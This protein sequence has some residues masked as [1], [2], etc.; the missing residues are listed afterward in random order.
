M[1]LTFN[2]WFD[3]SENCNSVSDQNTRIR[4]T[5][6]PGLF[7][8]LHTANRKQ[9]LLP[10]YRQKRDAKDFLWAENSYKEALIVQKYEPLRFPPP[11]KEGKSFWA[12]YIYQPPHPPA[13][14]QMLRQLQFAMAD[15]AL[16]DAAFAPATGDA[17][18]CLEAVGERTPIRQLKRPPS[19]WRSS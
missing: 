3:S 19:W 7:F 12:S 16:H 18:A 6:L 14:P 9:G 2:I 1:N 13:A 15:L 10:P 8:R 4:C 11:L 5:T 17:F